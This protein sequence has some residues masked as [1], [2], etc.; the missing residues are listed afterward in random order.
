[1]V[2]QR[3]VRRSGPRGPGALGPGPGRHRRDRLLAGPAEP[4]RGV[5]RA[6]RTRRARARARAGDGGRPVKTRPRA[7]RPAV[8]PLLDATVLAPHEPGPAGAVTNT[9][10]FAWRALLKIK[11]T[12]EQLFDV[13]VTPIMFTVLFTYM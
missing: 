5:L 13:V 8:T 7:A 12:P 11:H 9:F 3:A 10:T 4:R 1:P 2:A 6:H